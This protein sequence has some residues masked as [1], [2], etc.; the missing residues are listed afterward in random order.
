[1]TWLHRAEPSRA[2]SP[3]PGVVARPVVFARDIEPAR[4]EWFLAGT[5]PASGD[6]IPGATPPS[7]L[8]PAPG[9]IIALDPDIPA[10][11]QRVIFEAAGADPAARFMLNGTDLGPADRPLLWRPQAGR[12]ILILV[13]GE[14]EDRDT[15]AF[16][17]RGARPQAARAGASEASTPRE[18]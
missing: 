3:P 16:E 10:P 8:T 17:V 15:V 4:T 2:P 7:I 14:A 13:D 11:R 6:P 5:E 1:M 18:E 12:H 9:T